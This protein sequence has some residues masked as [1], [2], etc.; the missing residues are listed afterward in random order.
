MAS[1]V[2]DTMYNYYLSTYGNSTVSRY[3]SHKKSELRSVYNNIVKVNKESPLYKI[4]NSTDMQRFAIDIKEHAR[5]INNVIASLSTGDSLKETFQK[6]VA[7]SDQKDVVDVSYIGNGSDGENTDSFTIQ[8]K[9]LASAQVNQG[10]YLRQNGTDFK[11]GSYSFDLT[12]TNNSYEF[13]FTVNEE[14]SNRDVQEKLA[15]LFNTAKI[16]IQAEITE[17]E[18]GESALSLTSS[19]TGLSDTE[20]F[21]FRISPDG[22]N[23]SADAIQKL[24]IGEITT[25]AANSSFLLNGM[26]RSS[27]ANTFTINNTFEVHLKSI[28]PDDTAATLGFKPNI[29]AAEDNIRELVNAYNSIIETARQYE[30]RQKESNKLLNDMGKAAIHY[31]DAFEQIGLMVQDDTTITIDREKLAEA[32]ES[33][34]AEQN[35]SVLHHFKN[36]L[37]AK[38]TQASINPMQYVNKVVVAYKNPGKNFATPYITSMYSGMMLDKYL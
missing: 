35:F 28:S 12:T 27:Y 6:K 22:S 10:N 17:N 2:T 38:A 26:A 21:L 37:S 23:E 31:R 36:S 16:G 24:G 29:D 13:Q 5:Q 18:S 33:E 32:I 15:R 19:Q 14:D 8:V 11:P 1:A 4:K 34:N 20:E 25:P 7:V 3:D 30:G 9:Q